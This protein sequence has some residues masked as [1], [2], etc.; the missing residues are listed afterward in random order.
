LDLSFEE[1]LMPK[2]RMKDLAADLP[3]GGVHA[4]QAGGCGGFTVNCEGCTQSPT[5][6]IGCTL[7]CTAPYTYAAEAAGACGGFSH[8]PT[9]PPWCRYTYAEQV[10]EAGNPCLGCTFQ[11]TLCGGCSHITN[12]CLGCTQ[13]V[14]V[15]CGGCSHI[16]NPCLGCTHAI[17]VACGGCSQITNPCLGC[18]QAVTVPCGGCSQ[19]TN[20]CI[21]CTGSPTFPEQ[22]ACG[23][24]TRCLPL[25]IGPVCVG[26]FTHH[27]GLGPDPAQLAA[28]KEQ[29]R[30]QLRQIEQAEASGGLPTDPKQAAELEERLTGQLERLREHRASLDKQGNDE[31]REGG[32]D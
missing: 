32:G 24:F 17:T 30:A 25:T 15:A 3:A 21:G 31:S 22:V 13:A 19:I 9:I 16:T 26:G 29:L 2:F 4:H 10:Q 14:T 1:W 18:T 11:A 5:F 12:P 23:A 7:R 6:C 8:S 20:P 28:L 27:P